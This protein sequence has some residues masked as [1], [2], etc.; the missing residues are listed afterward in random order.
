MNKHALK[1]LWK[2]LGRKKLHIAFLMIAQ[3]V[4][5]AAGVLEVLLLKNPKPFATRTLVVAFAGMIAASALFYFSIYLPIYRC[6]EARNRSAVEQAK[7]SSVVTL[8]KLPYPSYVHYGD[9]KK[10][11][12]NTRYKLFYGLDED[13]NFTF[14]D[15]YSDTK[16]AAPSGD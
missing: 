4:S 13:V 14:A 15:P 11:P 16:Q 8:T 12:W 6:S 3:A 7:T 5:G 10:A 2:V 9:P 1:W